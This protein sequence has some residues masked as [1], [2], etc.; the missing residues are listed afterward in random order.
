MCFIYGTPMFP[1]NDENHIV[2]LIVYEVP[3][4]LAYVDN[5]TI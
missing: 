5:T 2:C 4:Y 3:I 1:K